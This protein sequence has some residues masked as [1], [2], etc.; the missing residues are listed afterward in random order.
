VLLS[1]PIEVLSAIALESTVDKEKRKPTLYWSVDDSEQ[2]PLE[3]LRSLDTVVIAFKDNETVEDLIAE[4]LVKLPQAK[5]VSPGKTG[6][7]GILTLS[8]LQPKQ[9]GIAESQG[10]EL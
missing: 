10:W 1:D 9:S 4:I 5:Q 6:W 3:L 8:K 7:N 2:L